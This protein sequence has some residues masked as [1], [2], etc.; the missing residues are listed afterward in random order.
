ML[1]GKMTPSIASVYQP[2]GELDP[3]FSCPAPNTTL[4][5][6]SNASKMNALHTK[7]RNVVRGQNDHPPE[8]PTTASEKA[9]FQPGDEWEGNP[10]YE[11]RDNAQGQNDPVQKRAK[12]PIQPPQLYYKC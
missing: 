3:G 2:P 9:G 6:I 4:E 7:D 12:Q 1:G 5:E 11:M 10:G 8:S